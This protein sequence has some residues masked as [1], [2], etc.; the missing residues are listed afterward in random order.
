VVWSKKLKENAMD[1]FRILDFGSH[2][3]SKRRHDK[4]SPVQSEAETPHKQGICGLSPRG[5][6]W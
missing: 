4:A 6:A 1:G 2:M 3:A 5:Y